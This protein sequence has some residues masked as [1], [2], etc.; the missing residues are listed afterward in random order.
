MSELIEEATG[1][2]EVGFVLIASSPGIRYTLPAELVAHEQV[3]TCGTSLPTPCHCGQ[4]HSIGDP[5]Y[6]VL[7]VGPEDGSFGP[8]Q[9]CLCLRIAPFAAPA[10]GG[11]HRWVTPLAHQAADERWTDMAIAQL[12][13]G[14]LVPGLIFCDIA[15]LRDLPLGEDPLFF[16][17]E[18]DDGDVVAAMR[19][20]VAR[21]DWWN[22]SA[23]CG[24]VRHTI[25]KG[26]SL[27][28]I[29]DSAGLVEEPCSELIKLT[30][31]VTIGPTAV[32][33]ILGR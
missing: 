5:F 7:I 13:V 30:H 10:P 19:R 4:T 1:A 32:A 3:H 22:R 17:Y 16:D 15:D 9:D 26:G 24:L 20:L 12:L 14:V 31:F 18:L 29:N 25:R 2:E 33:A 21:A 28:E 11:S 27:R 23:A 8:T 6:L